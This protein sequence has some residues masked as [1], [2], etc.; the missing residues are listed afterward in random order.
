MDL[1]SLGVD[2]I[3]DDFIYSQKQSDCDSFQRLFDVLLR[4]ISKLY[5]NSLI[6][7]EYI[8]LE[9]FSAGCAK[10]VC[11]YLPIYCRLCL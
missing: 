2:L 8:F 9:V 3:F 5:P 7:E 11:F 6:T 10:K 1:L 4:E